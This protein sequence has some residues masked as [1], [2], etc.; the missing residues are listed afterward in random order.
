MGRKKDKWA[1]YA[2]D[3]EA[4][5]NEFPLSFSRP[6]THDIYIIPPSSNKVIIPSQAW[7]SIRI[8]KRFESRG[9]AEQWKRR[10]GGAMRAV[11]P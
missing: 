9:Q 1:S 11:M 8:I 3:E 5:N 10:E 4:R 2:W 7:N 6:A